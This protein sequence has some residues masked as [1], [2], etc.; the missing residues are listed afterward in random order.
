LWEILPDLSQS[1]IDWHESP[2]PAE[3]FNKQKPP[4]GH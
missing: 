4:T 3:D 2:H 1:G